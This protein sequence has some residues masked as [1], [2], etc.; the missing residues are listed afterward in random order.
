[1]PAAD[2]IAV[3]I[4]IVDE[5]DDGKVMLPTHLINDALTAIDDYHKNLVPDASWK[6]RE[7]IMLARLRVADEMIVN[8]RS[9]IDRLR[10][11]PASAD[12]VRFTTYAI[13][14]CNA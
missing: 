2:P 9:E 4:A 12:S 5:V 1:M 14:E 11:P 8:L 6:Q 13:Q 3:L 7:Q 10:N